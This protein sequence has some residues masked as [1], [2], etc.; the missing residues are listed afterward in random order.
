MLWDV[1]K[2][3]RAIISKLLSCFIYCIMQGVKYIG[4]QSGIIGHLISMNRLVG[5]KKT[6][7]STKNNYFY[8]SIYSNYS[9]LWQ[10]AYMI[11][12]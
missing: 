3:R 10:T 5:R 9:S 4:K 6:V 11:L 7:A 2:K 1:I 8:N 12:E